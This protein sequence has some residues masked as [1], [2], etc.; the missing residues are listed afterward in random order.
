MDFHT[1]I[2]THGGF[3]SRHSLWSGNFADA[4]DRTPEPDLPS[5]A[6]ATLSMNKATQRKQTLGKEAKCNC[7]YQFDHSP[8]LTQFDWYVDEGSDDGLLQ[9]LASSIV[10]QLFK[11]YEPHDTVL[12]IDMNELKHKI[13][14]PTPQ[15]NPQIMFEQIAPLENQFK[16][17]MMSSE[18]IAIALEKLPSEYQSVLTLEMSKEGHRIIP[19]HI[20]DV[21]FQ[22]WREVYSSYAKNTIIDSKSEDKTDEKEVALMAFNRTCH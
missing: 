9:G 15:S 18:K 10:N 3:I 6:S 13:G 16:T 17:T 8:G 4:I 5:T 11:Q 19:R 2:S 12:M 14:L 22:Y 1:W 20:E 21:A 7:I